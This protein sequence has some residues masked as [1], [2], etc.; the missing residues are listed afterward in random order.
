MANMIPEETINSVQKSADIVEVIGEYVQLKKQ[1][2]NYFGLCP[3]HGENTPSFSVSADKQIFHCF[4]CG[5]G[6][7]V[8]SFLKQLEGYSFPQAVLVLAEKYHIDIPDDVSHAAVPTSEE[9]SDDLKMIEA[10]ELSK[11]FY[12]HLLVN[13][14]EGQ[15]AL[16]YLQ[17]RGFSNEDI[18]K[19][20]IGY[21][22][23][24]WDFMTKFL[25]KRG[26]DPEMMA[27]AGLLVKK[28]SGDGYFDRFRNRII[29]PIH[30]HHGKT[31]AFSGR[32]LADNQQPKYMNSPES[33]LFHK[34]KLL[35][36]F[37]QSRVHIR[38]Q[39]RA[40]LFEGFADVISAVKSGVNEAIA[41]M[42]TSLT[43][44]HARLIRRNTNEV[45][46]C[47]DS[48]RAGFEA[49]QK[50]AELLIKKDCKVRIAMMPDHLDPD[51]YIRK[52]GGDKFK[53][54]VIGASVSFMAFK[55]QY[56]KKGKN[57]SDEGERISYIENVLKEIS[58]LPTALEKEVYIK[59]LSDEFSLSYDSLQEQLSVYDHNT[60]QA[61]KKE[62]APKPAVTQTKAK[63][64]RIRPAYENAER[65]LLA[66]MVHDPEMIRKVL[67]RIG[68]DFNLDEHRAIAAYIYAM[69]EEGLDVSISK[70][71]G[72]MNDQAL[73]QI[74]SEIVMGHNDREI[75]EEELS[76]YTR[77]ILN[78]RNKSVIREKEEKR[79]EAERKKDFL[80]AAALAQE[81]VKLTRSLK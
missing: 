24:S 34:S 8:F 54:D 32:S 4:G 75:S 78:Y 50:A 15:E 63:P 48:D 28:E 80:A 60:Q 59:Q 69:Y 56:F 41:T 57:L 45:I 23:N 76:D 20:E 16:D 30:D 47:Y 6:G 67:D 40:V 39:E 12:H 9:G 25:E 29:F 68:L 70:L 53:T 18:E 64:W 2:R 52:F 55:L 77:K 10:H 44:E 42:G 37:H 49:A 33:P 36:H 62:A 27:K 43:D 81:I 79:Q 72:K 11:K 31:V 51:D 38:K 26:F 73:N 13:T 21:S 3:F 17:D 66:H 71:M 61:Q 65:T 58:R 46:I 22:L 74:L 7:D 19:F 14:K 35:Y 5:A 1:G